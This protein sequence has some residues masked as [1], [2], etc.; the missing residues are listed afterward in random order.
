MTTTFYLSVT[1]KDDFDVEETCPI[2]GNFMTAKFESEDAVV[3]QA[4]G[5]LIAAIGFQAREDQKNE[6]P[7]P[8]PDLND[9]VLHLHSD[10][11][12]G[13]YE[14]GRPEPKPIRTERHPCRD[15]PEREPDGH[16]PTAKPDDPD[17][18]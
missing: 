5:N 10:P 12:S 11:D 7:K 2:E 8:E 9:A 15:E 6:N 16:K 17:E 14:S 13:L 4:L 3:L 1:R 18:R